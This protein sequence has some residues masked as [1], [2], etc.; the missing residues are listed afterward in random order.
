LKKKNSKKKFEKFEE[1]NYEFITEN[2]FFAENATNAAAARRDARGP[3]P[4][5]DG[6][7]V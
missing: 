1:K 3:H 5:A 6:K 4:N 7:S 2:E